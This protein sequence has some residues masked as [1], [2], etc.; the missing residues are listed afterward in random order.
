MNDTILSKEELNLLA[1]LVHAPIR[2][3]VWDLDAI[4]FIQ[5]S[6]TIRVE[7]FDGVPATPNPVRN[8]EAVALR[9]S[10]I[11]ETPV[12]RSA[13]ED[14]HYYVVVDTNT[15]IES[16]AVVRTALC[17]PTEQIVH[18]RRGCIGGTL[19]LCDCGILIA[20]ARGFVPAVQRDNSFGFHLWG[21][22]R[23]FSREEVEV[24]LETDYETRALTSL[25]NA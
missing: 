12:F 20:T 10:E 15:R 23:L 1:S 7:S 8:V 18:P 17:M 3:L 22:P 2:Q 24:E 19:T 13:G 4:Y 5:A 21:A 14:G 16:I 11:E 25:A 9:V 6:R